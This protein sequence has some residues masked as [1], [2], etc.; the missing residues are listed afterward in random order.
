MYERE[1]GLQ[2]PVRYSNNELATGNWQLQTNF[3]LLIN[4]SH[5]DQTRIDIG[6]SSIETYTTTT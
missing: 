3:T 4:V 5:F 6:D 1:V 2:L